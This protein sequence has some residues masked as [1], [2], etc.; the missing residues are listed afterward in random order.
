MRSFSCLLASHIWVRNV[1]L[2][3]TSPRS[4][5]PDSN[6][7]PLLFLLFFLTNARKVHYEWGCSH[8]A[9]G[10]D[11]HAVYSDNRQGSFAQADNS[12]TPSTAGV[13][14]PDE[15]C[16]GAWN[17]ERLPKAPRAARDMCFHGHKVPTL[18]C[19]NSFTEMYRQTFPMLSLNIVWTPF[20]ILSHWLIHTS[21]Q[22]L[23]PNVLCT[24]TR[25]VQKYYLHLPMKQEGLVIKWLAKK[26]C[27]VD[28]IPTYVLGFWGPAYTWF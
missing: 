18:T 24:V 1:T 7:I 3:R 13:G 14:L 23:Q 20:Y 12:S 9:Q 2:A 25:H 22:V 10:V 15:I 11:K 19:A 8:L 28:Y 17:V 21:L 26:M 5:V 6:G 4:P 27:P 16:Y